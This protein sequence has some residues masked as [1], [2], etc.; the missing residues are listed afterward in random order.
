MLL[1]RLFY[2]LAALGLVGSGCGMRGSAG[3]HRTIPFADGRATTRPGDPRGSNLSAVTVNDAGT[4]DKIKL[5]LKLHK[6]ARSNYAVKVTTSI[7][8]DLGSQTNTIKIPPIIEDLQLRIMDVRDGIA[9]FHYEVTGARLD[10]EGLLSSSQV[11]TLRSYLRRLVGLGRD[12]KIDDRGAVLSAKVHIPASVPAEARLTL[13]QFSDQLRTVSVPL[14]EEAFGQDASW[15]SKTKLKLSG[16]TVEVSN[17]YQLARIDGSRFTI[18]VK[19]HQSAEPQPIKLPSLPAGST[20]RV[21]DWN[22]EA[23]GEMTLKLAN[24]FPDAKL[25][26]SGRQAFTVTVD[27]DDQSVKQDLSVDTELTDLGN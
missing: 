26:A 23:S 2:V 13:Q 19:Q 27:N 10:N 4:G 17:E 1:R 22:V 25:H 15:T 7:I 14:P 18:D 6:G 8:Q 16:A 21:V 12:G 20:A 3:Q 24:I 5:R 9:S 11:E